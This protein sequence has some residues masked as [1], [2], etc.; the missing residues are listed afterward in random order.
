MPSSSG[1]RKACA[2]DNAKT[3]AR[4]ASIPIARPRASTGNRVADRVTCDSTA[5]GLT[6]S[7]AAAGSAFTIEAG[8]AAL[9]MALRCQKRTRHG[10]PGVTS[11]SRRLAV[12]PCRRPCPAPGWTAA[13]TLCLGTLCPD[14]LIE[15]A[16]GRDGVR[17]A[18]P[19]PGAERSIRRAAR[20][21]ERPACAATDSAAALRGHAAG[22]CTS[23]LEVRAAAPRR[24]YRFPE[25]CRW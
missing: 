1:T 9:D 13:L 18:V 11:C 21:Q 22:T 3:V 25:Y 10:Y 16:A 17:P 8:A 20:S 5:S 2:H 14:P 19:D 15:G 12:R 24:G 4:L 6:C 7:G 23:G